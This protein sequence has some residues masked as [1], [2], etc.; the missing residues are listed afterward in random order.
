MWDRIELFREAREASGKVLS[1]VTAHG[2]Q[3]VEGWKMRLVV[4]DDTR[5]SYETRV[6]SARIC[7]P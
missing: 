3:C 4:T 2:G 7:L 1:T 6:S 5:V